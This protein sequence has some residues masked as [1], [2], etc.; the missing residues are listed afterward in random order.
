MPSRHHAASLPLSADGV[1][2]VQRLARF[3]YAARGTVYVLVG[4]IAAR[5][6]FVVGSP[7]GWTGT[8]QELLGRGGRWL[9]LVVAA[10]LGAHAL[11]R[12][13]QALRDPDHHDGKLARRIPYLISAVI[14]ASLAITALQLW[15][16]KPAPQ[17]TG[18][19]DGQ[20]QLAAEVLSHPLGDVLL[21]LVGVGV[22]GYAVQQLVLAFRGDI[23]GQLTIPDAD[24]HR[25]IVTIGRIGTAARA[26]VLGILGAF[27]IEAARH[28]D[29]GAA[30]GME[31][32]LRA[33]GKGWLLGAVAL[34][35]VAYG[36]FMLATAA[37][38]RL[39]VR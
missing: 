13:L 26:V 35:L 29:P 9:V 39:P 18:G 32:A 14:H 33:F 10:G 15:R 23:A 16:G 1:A 4:W 11:W 20:Q 22:I 2:W 36:V 24:S 38:R 30:G 31:G 27:L 19:A 37:Y 3:G 5:A 21:A 17:G 34:G 12:L 6:A 28:H 25:A 8:L 7:E